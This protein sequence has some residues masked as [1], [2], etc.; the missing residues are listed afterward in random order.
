MS[1]SESFLKSI[2]QGLLKGTTVLCLEA[3]EHFFFFFFDTFVNF[4]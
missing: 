2:E 4:H 1:L 3:F